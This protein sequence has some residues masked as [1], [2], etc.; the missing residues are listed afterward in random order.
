MMQISA[1]NHLECQDGPYC[2]D[3][4]EGFE[5][6]VCTIWWCQQHWDGSCCVDCGDI[7]C[8]HC[9]NFKPTTGGEDQCGSCQPWWKQN[10]RAN[11]FCSRCGKGGE[12]RAEWCRV[13]S[14]KFCDDC[15]EEMSCW[16]CDEF[17]CT[18]CA[19]EG[20]YCETCDKYVCGDCE[21][22]HEE[23]CDGLRKNEQQGS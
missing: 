22:E 1:L 18:R 17:E 21:Y 16:Y 4:G 15:R 3:C 11:Y 12:T 2:Q 23:D 10:K 8:T 5:C 9:G 19:T 6:C 20:E 7:C 14:K 13:C